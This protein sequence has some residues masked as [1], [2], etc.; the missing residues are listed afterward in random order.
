[1][2]LTDANGVR[3]ARLRTGTSFTSDGTPWH[4]VLNIG[5]TTVSY[6]IIETK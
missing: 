4:E 5:D 6:L 3:E 1:M 2:R